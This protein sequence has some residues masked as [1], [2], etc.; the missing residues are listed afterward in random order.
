M[1]WIKELDS[2]TK[3][4]LLLCQ[5]LS[6][7]D[8]N[9]KPHENCWSV[10]ENLDHLIVVNETYFP[11]L[12]ALKN[13]TY[14]KPFLARINFLVSFFGREITKAVKPD[15]KK[16]MKTFPIWEPA[17]SDH[18]KNILDR[19]EI[20]QNKLKTNIIE[21]KEFIEKGIVIS[22]P[23]N[24]NIVYKLETAFDIIVLHEQRHLEQA[25]DV[26]RILKKQ[27]L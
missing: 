10:A 16:K 9:W 20:H 3:E 19:F 8:L 26:C 25:K 15:T 2:V 11:V 7:E 1:N 22:S 24:R 21:A 4:F 17:K 23:A 18:N 14:K 6:E 27:H 12:K 5:N 13:N